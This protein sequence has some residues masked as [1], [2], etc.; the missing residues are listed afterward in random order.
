[1]ET[2]IARFFFFFGCCAEGIVLPVPAKRITHQITSSGSK[3]VN[4]SISKS[5]SVH[6][7][8]IYHMLS[9]KN[10]CV[11]RSLMNTLSFSF[12]L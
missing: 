12:V 11:D 3:P 1:M 6:V 9:A 7:T 2:Y 8:H 10:A 4:F 5:K